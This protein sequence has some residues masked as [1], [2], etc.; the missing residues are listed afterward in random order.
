[1]ERK[2]G[3]AREQFEFYRLNDLIGRENQARV[4]D[5]FVGRNK[6]QMRCCLS[7]E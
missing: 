4:I 1:M 2:Q 6:W 5:A 3:M 7:F